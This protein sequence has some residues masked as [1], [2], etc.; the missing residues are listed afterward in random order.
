M[1]RHSRL[2]F[3]EHNHRLTVASKKKKEEEI[4]VVVKGKKKQ[5]IYAGGFF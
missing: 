4:A 5:K 2:E 1:Q 3:M